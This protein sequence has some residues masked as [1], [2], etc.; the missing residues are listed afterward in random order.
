MN[1]PEIIILLFAF[2]G[3]YFLAFVLL[4]FILDFLIEKSRKRGFFNGQW[5]TH[6][7]VGCSETNIIEKAAIARVGLGGNS[8]E[9][10]IYW[11]AFFDSS[12]QELNTQ[13]EYEIIINTPIPVDYENFGFWSIT[14][15][16]KDKFLMENTLKKYLVRNQE[17][18][19]NKYPVKIKLSRHINNST[20]FALIPLSLKKQKFSLALRC[21]R[22]LEK[23]RSKFLCAQLEL[24]QINRIV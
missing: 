8:P 16:G 10:T 21:Y 2:A 22:P 13:F 9:E 4:P 3:G 6:F 14:V 23:M 15:Y 7:G 18:G 12:G 11:N 5:K 17:I 24:P 1:M 20:E 19:E